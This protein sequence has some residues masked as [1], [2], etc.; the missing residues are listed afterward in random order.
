VCQHSTSLNARRKGFA[1][2]KVVEFDPEL[3]FESC[4]VCGKNRNFQNV[5]LCSAERGA[6]YNEGKKARAKTELNAATIAGCERPCRHKGESKIQTRK[7]NTE[8]NPS[9]NQGPH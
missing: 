8:S 2:S 1:E 7:V 4:M 5:W 3:G 6:D 9:P